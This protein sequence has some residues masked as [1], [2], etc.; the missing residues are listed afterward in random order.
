MQHETSDEYSAE[1]ETMETFQ[2]T[3]PHASAPRSGPIKGLV[4]RTWLL[5]PAAA[6]E[7]EESLK[8]HHS[9]VRTKIRIYRGSRELLPELG[10]ED[11][12]TPATPPP[13]HQAAGGSSESVARALEAHL[14]AINRSID[15]AQARLAALDREVEDARGRRD[16]ELAANLQLVESSQTASLKAITQ[17]RD[18]ALT[19]QAKA[20]ELDRLSGTQFA[21]SWLQLTET[22][23]AVAQVRSVFGQSVLA[24]RLEKYLTIGKEV[25]TG[26]AESQLGQVLGLTV[27]GKIAAAVGKAT[28]QNF[29]AEEV[30]LATLLQAPVFTER[31]RQLQQYAALAPGRVGQG[32]LLGTA[33]CLGEA[34]NEAVQDFVQSSTALA[35]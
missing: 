10:D 18:H 34:N 26:V 13:P 19:E 24:D 21:G 14:N 20:F 28:G 8:R 7:L 9:H 30:M 5:P 16:K 25:V 6:Q 23:A 17:A 3:V 35:A 29:S 12:L 11:E 31:R 2:L 4:I 32:L 22:A 33:F 15:A 27:A 1:P